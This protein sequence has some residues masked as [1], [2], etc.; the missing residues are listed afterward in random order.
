T[1]VEVFGRNSWDGA[2]ILRGVNLNNYTQ[3]N[4]FW[5]TWL[6]LQWNATAYEN[7]ELL[8]GNRFERPGFFGLEWDVASNPTRPLSF[9]FSG[10]AT[11]TRLGASVDAA[12]AVSLQ[13]SDRLRLSLAPTLL[14]VTG[15]IRRV[16]TLGVGDYR[17]GLQDAVGTGLTLR[18]SFTFTPK[19]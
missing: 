19:A 14:R 5:T 1:S 3:W 4:N 17:F 2:A 12:G 10:V 7:R 9:D 15:D 8:D 16:E 13:A 6:E 11:L 18:S